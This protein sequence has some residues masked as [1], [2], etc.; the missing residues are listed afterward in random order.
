[1]DSNSPMSA[2]FCVRGLEQIVDQNFGTL[3]RLRRKHLW[4]IVIEEQRD[5]L[6]AGIYDPESY[7][8]LCYEISAT[9]HRQAHIK[10][11]QDYEE[12]LEQRGKDDRKQAALYKTPPSK[13]CALTEGASGS[14][15]RFLRQQLV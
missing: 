6:T 3:R 10:A 13:R 2:S 8:E 4:Y 11:M 12:V 9:A 14:F 1:M 15:K 5:Q 7:E